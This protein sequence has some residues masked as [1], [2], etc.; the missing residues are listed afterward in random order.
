MTV[1]KCG[2]PACCHLECDPQTWADILA[3][4]PWVLAIMEN[5][6]TMTSVCR[7]NKQTTLRDRCCQSQFAGQ[8]TNV[9]RLF[10]QDH[11][12]AGK[13]L[14]ISRVQKLLFVLIFSTAYI[15]YFNWLS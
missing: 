5:E 10:P 3:C 6:E 13:Q 9:A 1:L 7:M 8:E 12:P 14:Q 4:G 2:G 15:L 11:S